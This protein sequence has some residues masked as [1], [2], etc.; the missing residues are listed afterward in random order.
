M[1]KVKAM[2]LKEDQ[3]NNMYVETSYRIQQ[4][5]SPDVYKI[6]EKVSCK[7]SFIEDAIFISYYL[8]FPS[9]V[10]KLLKRRDFEELEKLKFEVKA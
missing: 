1:G 6:F 7:R 8:N 2:M 5:V 9:E 4:T 3:Q 10:Y